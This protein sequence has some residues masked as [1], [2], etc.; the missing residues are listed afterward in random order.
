MV[1]QALVLNE[2]IFHAR[3]LKVSSSFPISGSI[4][5]GTL[6]TGRSKAYQ[7]SRYEWPWWLPW[8]GRRERPWR[9]SRPGLSSSRRIS[10]WVQRSWQRLLAVLGS[11]H[12]FTRVA[13]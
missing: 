5:T 6:V 12:V 10:W 8:Q 2:S 7:S 4:L 13:S 9:L 3:P 11:S 1:A